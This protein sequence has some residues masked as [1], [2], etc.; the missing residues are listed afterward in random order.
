MESQ[1]NTTEDI[2]D[3]E[4]FDT[5]PGLNIALSSRK[6][7][8]VYDFLTNALRQWTDGIVNYALS[9]NIRK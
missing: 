9:D 7:R 2:E 8:K 6:K 3:P 4:V 1:A 5:C